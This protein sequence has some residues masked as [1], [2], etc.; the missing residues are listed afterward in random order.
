MIHQCWHRMRA[1]AFPALMVLMI[2]MIL[3]A[4]CAPEQSVKPG[5]NERWRSPEIEPLIG[6]IESESREIYVNRALLAAVVA[7][8]PGSAVADVGAGS[9]FMSEQFARLVGPS[10]MVYAVDI[11]PVMME[12]VAR[13]AAENGIEIIETVV[14]TDTSV[15]LPPSSVDMIFICDTYHHFEYP[16][17][18]MRSIRRALRPGGEIVLVEFTREAGVSRQWVMDH[19]RAGRSVFTDEITAAGFELIE[20]HDVPFLRENYVLRFR[21]IARE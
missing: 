18:T 4:G 13:K 5:I 15:N 21:K 7:P 2:H 1:M 9:G 16:V 12:H 3:P 11:N 19:V 8:R 17:S 14:C 20:V 6:S 10:G